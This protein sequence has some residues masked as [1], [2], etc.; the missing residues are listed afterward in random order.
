M[1]RDERLATFDDLFAISFKSIRRV[2]KFD[3]KEY[4]QKIVG[5]PVEEQFD[6]RIIDHSAATYEAAAKHTV[7]TFIQVFPSNARRRGN[8]PIRQPS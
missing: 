1:G 3:T 4:L 6:L 8:R 2:V 7:V 5:H